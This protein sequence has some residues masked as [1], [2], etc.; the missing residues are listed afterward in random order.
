MLNK[1]KVN[2]VTCIVGLVEHGGVYIG[3]DSSAVSGWDLM[4]RK[5]RK[6][7]RL[8]SEFLFG[9]TSSFRMGQLLRD[10]FVAP[11]MSASEP[12]EHYMTTVFVDAVRECLKTGGFA[13]KKDEQESAGTFLV[14]VRGRLFRVADDYQTG[15]TL[16]GYDAI[17][18]GGPVALGALH[19]IR[20]NTTLPP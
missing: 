7:F 12:V 19:A 14:G 8:G 6:V 2:A 11:A 20:H 13:Q 18:S 5:D 1:R 4:P 9:F 17:G 15:E 16:D 10:A 3:R